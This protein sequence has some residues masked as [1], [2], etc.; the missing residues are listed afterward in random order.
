MNRGYV[1][2]GIT[3]QRK[4]TFLEPSPDAC[5]QGSKSNFSAS[6]LFEILSSVTGRVPWKSMEFARKGCLLRVE[7]SVPVIDTAFVHTRARA[8]RLR[9]RTFYS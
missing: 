1:D 2:V 5:G 6:V 7:M 8:L 4:R 3:S 9:L